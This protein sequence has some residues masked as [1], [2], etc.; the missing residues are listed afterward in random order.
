MQS[1]GLWHCDGA[2]L[3][4][5]SCP[6]PFFQMNNF[7]ESSWKADD[8]VPLYCERFHDLQKSSSELFGPRAPFL[9][10][11]QNGCAG[12][13]LKLPFLRIVHVS[14]SSHPTWSSPC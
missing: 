12:A 13:L 11:M 4:D 9:L 7:L 5:S 2:L 8:F 6:H 1:R 14:C 3:A 10:A